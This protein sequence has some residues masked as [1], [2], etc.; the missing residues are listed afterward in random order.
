MV[1]WN[2]ASG[3]TLDGMMLPGCPREMRLMAA[4]D[5][6]GTSKP[7]RFENLAFAQSLKLIVIL[8]ELR[9]RAALS[10]RTEI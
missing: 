2:K 9:R 4:T 5:K 3:K 10:M 6:F 1:V 8:S 7:I